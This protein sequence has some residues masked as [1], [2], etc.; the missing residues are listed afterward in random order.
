MTSVTLKKMSDGLKLLHVPL[1]SHTAK[2][3]P[4]SSFQRVYLET[5][6]N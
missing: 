5:G 4:A 6:L 2:I 3:L 1:P